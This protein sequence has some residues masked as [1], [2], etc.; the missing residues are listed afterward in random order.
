MIDLDKRYGFATARKLALPPIDGRAHRSTASFD[1]SGLGVLLQYD[2]PV[3]H[4]P[5]PP[6]LCFEN[7]WQ[8]QYDVS[9][10]ETPLTVGTLEVPVINGARVVGPGIVMAKNDVV[11]AES[12]GRHAERYGLELDND[13]TCTV[14]AGLKRIV[15][16]A[17][18]TDAVARHEGTALLLLG[19]GIQH[20]G[21]CVLKCFPKL[22][23][24]RLLSDTDVR[25]VVPTDV[26]RT[27]TRARGRTR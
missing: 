22:A 3:D 1:D 6:P 10:C 21:M 18:R 11:L 5:Q 8:P 4:I 26:L 12:V 19:P 25:V 17:L 16:R 13:G 27:Y 9:L 24:L 2:A 20:F 23:V 7:D 14:S 15:Q